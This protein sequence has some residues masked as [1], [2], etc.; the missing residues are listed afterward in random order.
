MTVSSFL[1]VFRKE[2]LHIR[3]DRGDAHPRR[4]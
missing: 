1:A 4:S 2:F 3:R